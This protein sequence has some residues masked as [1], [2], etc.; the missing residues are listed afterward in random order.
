MRTLARAVLATQAA[1]GSTRDYTKAVARL[2]QEGVPVGDKYHTWHH[3]EDVTDV[4][5]CCLESMAMEDSRD[6]PHAP[7]RVTRPE[8]DLSTA[9]T[10]G[11]DV[12]L[13]WA[14]RAHLYQLL[15]CEMHL[16]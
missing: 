8:P 6:K 9:F 13:T 1:R 12:A 11:R 5:A 2:W 16:A 14:A 3:A 4:A 15:R 7:V 10:Q